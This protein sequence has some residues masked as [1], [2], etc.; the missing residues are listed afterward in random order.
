MFFL[1]TT[2]FFGERPLL[3]VFMREIFRDGNSAPRCPNL[4]QDDSC[5]ER[6]NLLEVSWLLFVAGA[7]R[8]VA[9]LTPQLFN[10]LR[11]VLLH[12]LRELLARLDESAQV[13]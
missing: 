9:D 11:V 8:S 6:S 3:L 12:L 2:Q 5:L 13:A 1:K 10:E 7:G 4:Q